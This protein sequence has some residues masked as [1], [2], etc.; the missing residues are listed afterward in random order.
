MAQASS[1]ATLRLF[2]VTVDCDPPKARE[3]VAFHCPWTLPSPP[4]LLQGKS[5]GLGFLECLFGN[6]GFLWH[7]RLVV[8]LSKIYFLPLSNLN[9]SIW[10]GWP[11]ICDLCTPQPYTI[12]SAWNALAS[13]WQCSQLQVQFL[14]L[15]FMTIPTLSPFLKCVTYTWHLSQP[16]LAYPAENALLGDISLPRGF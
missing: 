7:S 5:A 15:S 1:A 12:V 3:H 10:L 14:P 4:H 8:N 11:S 2:N 16:I 9:P 13:L 6:T